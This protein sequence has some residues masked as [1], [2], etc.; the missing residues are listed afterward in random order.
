MEIIWGKKVDCHS[1][2]IFTYICITREASA[3]SKLYNRELSSTNDTH[4]NGKTTYIYLDWVQLFEMRSSNTFKA[5]RCLS[6]L[7]KMHMHTLG[8]FPMQSSIRRDL[9]Q[10]GLTVTSALCPFLDFYLC[11]ET[12]YHP[13]ST[14][15]LTDIR[16]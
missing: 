15:S 11:K 2:R 12:M 14:F 13:P 16:I 6:S 1:T 3:S 8:R 5:L 10:K 7:V 9:C 4:K